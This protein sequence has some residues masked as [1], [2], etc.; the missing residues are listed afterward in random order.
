[1]KASILIILFL[2]VN[3]SFGQKL[4]QE[5]K[6]EK[7]H[8]FLVGPI[9]LIGLQSEP[10]KNWFNSSYVNYS[11]DKSLTK[12]LKKQLKGY[13]LKLFLGTWCGDS[14]R[15]MPRMVKILEQAQFPLENLEIIALDRR[16]GFY[17]KS[18]S[19]EEK[20]LNIIKVPTLI[21]FKNGKEINR[22]VERPLASL[23]EDMLAILT[24][25]T[26]KP[27]YSK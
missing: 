17:K 1:M 6:T 20:G 14:K 4:N 8:Q 26:Y 27:N 18:P 19:G 7:G 12:L 10:Y 21:F 13:Q 9:N 16:K 22:I 15:E 2:S 3:L 5:I 24:S 11:V 23:E 25:E